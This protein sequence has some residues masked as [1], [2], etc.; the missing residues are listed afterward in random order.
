MM[1]VPIVGVAFYVP[2]DVD[3]GAIAGEHS[4]QDPN[5]VGENTGISSCFFVFDGS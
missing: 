2:N 1:L 3:V 4:S 5:M